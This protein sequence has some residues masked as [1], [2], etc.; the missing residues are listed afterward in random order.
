MRRLKICEEKGSGIDKVI[1]QCELYQL[2][3]P[4]FVSN[5]VHTKVILYAHKQLRE[6][7]RNDKIRAV[8]QHASLK[9]V[10]NARPAPW[11]SRE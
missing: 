7:D 10:S 6:M 8:Y 2:P 9:W 4:Y 5:E 1:F 3:A 11:F